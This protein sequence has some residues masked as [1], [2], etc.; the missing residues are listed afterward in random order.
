MAK[1]LLV[2]TGGDQPTSE[3][4][5]KAVM[6]AWN[7]WF[8]TLGHAVVDPGNPVGA[9]GCISADGSAGA[10]AAGVTGYS[11]IS[12]DTLDAALGL[13]KGCPHLASNGAVEV[14]ETFDVM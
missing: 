6:D 14:Y 3:E 8:G 10:A 1:Y 9:S 4:E 7:G 11:I 13:A 12:A 5:G 2:Y